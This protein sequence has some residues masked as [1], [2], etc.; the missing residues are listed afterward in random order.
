M[1]FD[2]IEHASDYKGISKNL[3]TALT[4]LKHI[5]VNNL[6]PGKNEIDGNEV[7]VMLF[8]YETKDIRDAVYE[9]HKNYFDIQLLLTGDEIFRATPFNNQVVTKDYDLDN[10]IE[11]FELSKGNDFHLSNGSFVLAM[12]G[13]LHAPGLLYKKRSKVKKLVIKIRRS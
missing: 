11:L 5:N 2:K 1:I 7:F 4:Y 8:E 13:E 6:K 9:S 12:P 3:D 10:D